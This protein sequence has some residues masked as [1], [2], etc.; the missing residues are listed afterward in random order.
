MPDQPLTD[1]EVRVLGALIE[2]EHTTP[3]AYPLSPNALT[4][5]C[6]Q[7][8]NREPVM[9]LD[10]PTV[11]AA[12][13]ALRGRS[14]VRPIVHSG[15]RVTKYEQRMDQALGLVKRQLA[16]LCVLML[17]GPQT[18]GELRTRTQRIHDFADSADVES[19]IDGLI[20]HDP[21]LVVRLPR[22]PGQKELRYAHLLAGEPSP[23]VD[24]A[25]DA[26]D[27]GRETASAGRTV[28]RVAALEDAVAALR[29][30]VAALRDELAMFRRQFE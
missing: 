16:V 27:A 29:D 4:A 15:G 12:V 23:D 24:E 28:D 5:A 14:L 18:A 10:E 21:P 2:K 8:S 22:R 13:H 17:R 25:H 7:T 30:E 3:D 9:T 20:D 11:S 19:T 26:A 1:V 6:N